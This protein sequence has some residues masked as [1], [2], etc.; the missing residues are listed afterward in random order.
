MS[1]RVVPVLT[2][3]VLTLVG[4]S[5]DEPEE[6]QHSEA[7]AVAE[8]YLDA[9]SAV[10]LAGLCETYSEDSRQA[11]FS[12]Y[13]VDNCDDYEV[14]F[15]RDDTSG[16]RIT[17]TMEQSFEMGDATGDDERVEVP[18]TATLTYVG[19][20][21]AAEEFYE[22]NP[23]VPGAVIVVRDGEE[24]GVDAEATQESFHLRQG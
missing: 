7:V 22:E 4:C 11:A 5:S 9:L 12:S 19:D 17:A 13:D 10:D 20:N 23:T 14:A 15:I 6:P 16:Y 8:A 2:V 3:V 1:P 24:W 18:F 21:D